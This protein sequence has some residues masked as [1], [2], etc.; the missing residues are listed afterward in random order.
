M[1]AFLGKQDVSDAKKLINKCKKF[2]L[3]SVDIFDTTFVR[4]TKRPEDI[5]DAMSSFAERHLVT[6]YASKRIEAQRVAEQ[7]FGSRTTL[8]S[9]YSKFQELY[10]IEGV[11]LEEIKQYEID[12]ELRHII[13]NKGILKL[14]EYCKITNKIFVFTSDMY[15]SQAQLEYM[16]DKKGI[17]NYS[18]LIVSCEY[19][20]S[21]ITG[22]LFDVVY[23]KY[24]SVCDRFVHIGDNVRTDFINA[25]KNKRFS[26]VLLQRPSN[27]IEYRF[28]QYLD[29]KN[30]PLYA[31]AY[32]YMGPCMYSFCEWIT[33]NA[34]KYGSKNI[35]FLTREGA[36]I[37]KY[38]EL[39]DCQNE[40]NKTTFFASR[41]SI[42]SSMAD[43][44]WD[45]V[46]DYIKYS[47]C[48]IYELKSIFQID[49]TKIE[50][51]ISDFAIDIKVPLVKSEYLEN[52]LEE[53]KQDM[54]QYSIKQRECFVEYIKQLKI[55]GKV[56]LVDI[57]WRGTMQYYLQ[58]LIEHVGLDLSLVGLY[59]GEYVEANITCDKHGFLCSM[60][61]SDRIPDVINASFV[62]ENTLLMPISS[63]V[64]YKAEG[65]RIYPVFNNKEEVFDSRIHVIQSGIEDSFKVL[66]AV[67]EFY[68]LKT[69][70]VKEQL[71]H[72]LNNPTYQLA[73]EI[74]D[75]EWKDIDTIRY[76]AKPKPFLSYLKNPRTLIYDMQKSG[77]N[78][79]FL[80][81]VFK[82][83][84]PYF[85]VYK[86]L[87]KL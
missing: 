42:L 50:N 19:G 72:T 7:C 62:L 17:R 60:E 84:L 55:Q 39:Y 29:V 37:Q 20:K 68:P 41:R 53:L 38:M 14:I 74:G 61:D 27:E 2:D 28:R 54:V 12:T 67:R 9:I 65:G 79:A 15:L 47:E 44:E 3:V 78:S 23:E 1:I 45:A 10:D 22:E 59:L 77:W 40:F 51:I 11:T 76:V 8:D 64:R 75:I 56:I 69:E 21:K 66:H 83:P 85:Y 57:G 31:W 6:D 13:V 63:T 33:K 4:L 87:K 36:Y 82:L 32:E 86:F 35:L 70:R 49:S 24:H 5:F 26:A 71:F 80:R 48:R 73:C 43:I 25:L 18:E 46:V 52:I 30:E 81:R 34:N 16:L 58:K